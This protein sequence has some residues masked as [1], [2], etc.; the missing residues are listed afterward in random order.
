MD[1]LDFSIKVMKGTGGHQ[2]DITLDCIP[3]YPFV[4]PV[5]QFVVGLK[6]EDHCQETPTEGPDISVNPLAVN[7]GSVL[8]NSSSVPRNVTVTNVGTENLTIGTITIDD[9][10]FA[11]SAGNIS[12]ETITPGGS[13]IISLTF[14]PSTT[15]AQLATLTIPSNDPDENPKNITLSG[16]GVEYAAEYAIIHGTVFDDADGDGVMG[17]GEAGIAGV[18]VTLSWQPN[19]SATR[20]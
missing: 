6:D 10:Q 7:F 4:D 17:T 8:V 15:G 18:T 19:A 2:G 1:E 5:P 12:D 20:S 3:V 14:T 13:D 16:T 11:I 9:P